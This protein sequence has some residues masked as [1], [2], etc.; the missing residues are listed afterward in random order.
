MLAII[1]DAPGMSRGDGSKMRR[2]IERS[3][4]RAFSLKFPVHQRERT[5]FE[6]ER[7]PVSLFTFG[8]WIVH[9]KQGRCKT[10]KILNRQDAVQ[11]SVA[12]A[13]R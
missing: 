2:K 12:S 3:E 6:G 4:E 8:A 10:K 13:R 1:H 11:L 5:V 9:D 7:E